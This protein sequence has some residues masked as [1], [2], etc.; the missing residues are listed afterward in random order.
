MKTR[1]LPTDRVPHAASTPLPELAAFLAPFHPAFARSEG[2]HLMERYITGLLSEHPNKN[3]DTL[4]QV[5]PGTSEQSFQGLLT[6]MVWDD[7]AVNQA[8]VQR[9]CALP[10]DGDGVLAVDDTGFLKKGT[11]SV[12]VARQY[13]GTSGKVDN[14]QVAVTCVYAERTLAW[15]VTTRLYMPHAWTDDPA[16]C[17]RAHVPEEVRF[18]TKHEIALDLI[19]AARAQGVPYACITVDGDYG[20]VPF[21]LDSLE[22]RDERYVGAVQCDFRVAQDNTG[23]DPQRADRL[24]DGQRRRSWRTL[25]WREGTAGPLKAQFLAVRAW[26]PD[27]L[28]RW[29][30]GWLLAERPARGRTG[31]QR[32][33]WSN[34]PPDT[35]LERLAED[36]H[37]RHWI[38][39]FH[40]EAKELLG[41]DQYQGRRWD[42]FHRH[43]LLVMIAYSFLVWQEWQQ[44]Q[45]QRPVGCPRGPFSPAPGSAAGVVGEPAP[46]D[47]GLAAGAG[48]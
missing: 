37:R 15:P 36:A 13:T 4:A 2:R 10:T 1:F 21:F 46:P 32:Y 28:G 42:G 48:V 23:A 45:R 30:E 26:R 33:S 8:R 29:R 3:C 34:L 17:A 18:Q 24:V 44:R 27:D 16:R 20:D 35:A 31:K 19:D 7:A 14:C 38:E 39:Q 11:A 12:G 43:A 47:R 40:E 6:T 5:I 22:G 41:W 25:T 9:M